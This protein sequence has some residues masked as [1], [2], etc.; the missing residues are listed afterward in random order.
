MR[1]HMAKW[2]LQIAV[3]LLSISLSSLGFAQ[4]TIENAQVC[5]MKNLDVACEKGD[6]IKFDVIRNHDNRGV[7]FLNIDTKDAVG[8][9]L[10]LYINSNKP[11]ILKIVQNKA[12]LRGVFVSY[13][14]VSKLKAATSV[15]F[16]IAMK[17][18]SPILGSLD[19]YHFD[20][21]KR[22]GNTCS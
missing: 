14:I 5:A 12:S 3:C 13:A 18:R 1:E 22:F 16:K 2:H 4:T 8:D 17:Q 6:K 19:K 10:E 15:H 9:H 21:L 11:E 7:V 20:W